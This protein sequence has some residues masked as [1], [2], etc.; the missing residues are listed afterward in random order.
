MHEPTRDVTPDD[1]KKDAMIVFRLR[2]DERDL[3]EQAALK[4]R[5][6]LSGYCRRVL[7]D[8][9]QRRLQRAS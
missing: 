6:R 3:I 9:A 8:S 1:L 5:M 7:L 2:E 4:S